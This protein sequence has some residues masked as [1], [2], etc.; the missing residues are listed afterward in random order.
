[1]HFFLDQRMELTKGDEDS[2]QIRGQIILSLMTRDGRGMG[3]SNDAQGNLSS[4]DDLPE[5]RIMKF[6]IFRLSNSYLS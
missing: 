2:E 5:V 4:P 3:N 1:M 6:H